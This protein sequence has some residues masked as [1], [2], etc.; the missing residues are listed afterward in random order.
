[1]S[2]S[3]PMHFLVVVFAG[4][5]NRQQQAV[6][7]YLQTE[8]EIL[9]SQFKR[10]RLRLKDEDRC[11]LAVKGRALGR[12]LLTE[13]ACIVTP[14]T[15]LA[16]HRR[17]VALKWTFRR[18][19]LGTSAGC[20]RDSR[21]NCGVGEQRFQ[22]G[23]HE[24]SR[25]VAQF[26]VPS[27]PLDGGK[28]VEGAR[29]RPGANARPADVVGHVHES[30]LAQFGGDRLHDSRGLDVRRLGHARLPFCHG[31][32]DVKSRV[33]WDYTTSRRGL[34]YSGGTQPD[35]CVQRV[36]SRKSLSYHGPR[37]LVPRGVSGLA[38][39]R[40][41][42]ARAHAGPFAQLHAHLERFHLSFKGEVANRMI[43]LGEDHLQRTIDEYLVYHH[44][45]RNH[46]GLA[47]QIIDPGEEMASASARICRRQRLGG[48]L[49]YYYRD[50][51]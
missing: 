23:L 39:K 10:R 19:T 26:G 25:S 36:P 44:S 29:D 6:I 47:G 13:V 42:F 12:K 35:G 11:R 38:Q 3:L 22:L 46:Q 1:M 50:A 33:R 7:E 16:W 14:D 5:M 49:N 20:G 27:E 4:W 45:E 21:A 8:N 40:W 37:R 17:L 2:M 41:R 30:A 32:G 43:F 34:D 48:M 28:R 18:R 31:T 51:A 9:K 24:H 15:I